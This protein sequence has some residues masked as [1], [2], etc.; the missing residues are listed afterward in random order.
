MPALYEV[1]S[2]C[3]K[4]SCSSNL[5]CLH[6]ILASFDASKLRRFAMVIRS[7]LSFSA[8]KKAVWPS[9]IRLVVLESS[10]RADVSHNEFCL[11]ETF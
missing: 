5:D 11:R 7:V 4:F 6:N 10:E 9:L 2:D 8:Y 3:S 1:P